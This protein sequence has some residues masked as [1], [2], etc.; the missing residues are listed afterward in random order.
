M[1]DGT[2]KEIPLHKDVPISEETS[3]FIGGKATDLLEKQTPREITMG[4]HRS[5]QTKAFFRFDEKTKVEISQTTIPASQEPSPRS[6]ISF[7]ESGVAEDGTRFEFHEDYFVARGTD[8]KVTVDKD[9]FSATDKY[10]E[11]EARRVKRLMEDPDGTI[12]DEE[13]GEKI[14]GGPISEDEGRDLLSKLARIDPVR[15][16]MSQDDFD[17]DSLMG[18]TD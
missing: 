9:I 16:I 11:A 6:H 13:A 3:I 14:F 4:P 2:P 12:E 18:Y 1:A 7:V 15:H 17:R 10:D 5:L 8:G